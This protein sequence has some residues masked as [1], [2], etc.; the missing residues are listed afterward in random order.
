MKKL[1]KWIIGIAGIVLIYLLV[2][3]FNLI[4]YK[5]AVYQ[6]EIVEKISELIEKDDSKII[7]TMLF[8]TFL[9]G[10]VH[11]FG[12]GHGKTLV[13][14]Y[15]VKE[16]LNFPK[17]ILISFLIAYLQ[18]LS[19]YILVKFIINL[20][21][22]ASMMLFYDLDNRTRLIA[23][24]LIILIG[25]YNIYSLLRNKC[26]EHQH[27]TK[28][29]NILGFSIVLGL[30]P[31][32]GVMTVLLFLESFGL[33]KNLFLFTLSMSTGIFLVILFFGIL[34]NTF[35]KTLVEEEN[36]KLHKILSLVGASLMILF[37]VFQILILGE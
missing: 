25:L 13:L 19:A 6:Q 37:G 9:Y 33:S 3:N 23:S 14:T 36:L 24:I 17:L 11:S 7:Y 30:C 29:K 28:V 26:C 4:M 10:I 18:G 12:P 31:C 16:K 35:K 5:I 27:E 2:S 32:P 15:S 21:D 1:V 34:A 20:S 8:F 22:R